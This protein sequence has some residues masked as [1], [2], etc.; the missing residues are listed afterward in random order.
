M[1]YL[2]HGL[3]LSLL[4]QAGP[5]AAQAPE[6]IKH[7]RAGYKLLKAQNI[8]NA[9]IELEK[10]VAID[11]TYGAAFY[12]LAK[13]YRVL[14]EYP[15]AIKAY[16][17]AN[18]LGVGQDRIPGELARL[19]HKAAI[20]LFQQ[21]KYKEAVLN[22][23]QS[24]N[25][26]PNNA[27]AHYVMGLCHNGLRNSEAAQKAYLQAVEVDSNYAKPYKSLGDLRR[28]ERNYG[29]AI[30]AYEQAISLDPSF[31][32][33]YG[34]LAL[35]HLDTQNFE[36]LAA[37]IQKALAIDPEYVNGY[38]Y[39]GTAFNRLGRYHEAIKPLRRGIE[40]N[41]KNPEAHYLLA[42]AYYGKGDYRLAVEAGQSAVR[43]GRDYHAAE[44]LLGDTYAKL[45]QILE[46]RTWYH[47]AMKDSRLKDY[48]THKLE[49]LEGLDN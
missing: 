34:G 10:A 19:Y 2:F 21:H 35:V 22:F 1:K 31:M 46:A 28:R 43:H 3:V 44:M 25:F 20:K 6:A 37:L 30:Q 39:L 5:L 24:L 17:A 45:G 11:T 47:K 7:Y 29:G 26:D 48:C 8:R 4:L 41:P 40:L 32:E 23:E 27:K 16:Q 33:A 9:A 42:E 14:D 38:L 49:E 15:K 18:K 36:A 12:A 13:A